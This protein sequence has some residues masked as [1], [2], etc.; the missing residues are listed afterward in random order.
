MPENSVQNWEG[1]FLVRAVVV[2]P[3]TKNGDSGG[4]T[5]PHWNEG[6]I[7]EVCH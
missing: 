3:S 1:G 6:Q 5:V 7:V 4:V 2:Q